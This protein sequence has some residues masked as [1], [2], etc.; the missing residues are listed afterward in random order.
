VRGSI[1]YAYKA[2]SPSITYEALSFPMEDLGSLMYIA[3]PNK[4]LNPEN[5]RSIE[6]GLKRKFFRKIFVDLSFFYNKI[7]N[8]IVTTHEAASNLDLENVYYPPQTDTV[9]VRTHKNIE[10]A[11]STLYGVQTNINYRNII[12]SVKLNMEINLTLARQSE[13]LPEVGAI[14]GSFNFM[15]KHLGQ[16]NLSFEPTDRV[17]VR[18]ENVWMSKW[19]RV[20]IPIEEIYDEPYKSVDGYYTLDGLISFRLSNNL[21]IYLK[22]QN[23][24]DEK[25]G[26][27]AATGSNFDLPFNPQQGTTT[28][29][30]LTYNFN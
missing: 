10:D 29:F 6:L 28:R 27:I 20:L 23:V 12:E 18:F 7:D 17:Y 26:G 5:F 1:G 16:L 8:L 9:W 2:P 24:F 3:A 4:N 19:L 21:H 25:Y 13:K 22:V 30:G 14:I 11:Q 15:P